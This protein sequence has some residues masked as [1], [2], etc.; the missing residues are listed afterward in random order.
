META[1]QQIAR[2]VTIAI[3]FSDNAHVSLPEYQKPA[4]EMYHYLTH[5]G[6]NSSEHSEAHTFPKDRE[7]V[8][9]DLVGRLKDSTEYELRISVTARPVLGDEFIGVLERIVDLRN[10]L[11]KEQEKIKNITEILQPF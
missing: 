3:D 6:S 10:K 8:L 9:S 2:Y 7:G 1:I 4:Y 11:T 5:N